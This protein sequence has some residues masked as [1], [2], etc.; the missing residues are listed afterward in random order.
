MPEFNAQLNAQ[1]QSVVSSISTMLQ[2]EAAVSTQQKQEALETLKRQKEQ[3]KAA[4]DARLVELKNIKN[5]L[6]TIN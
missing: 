2:Q 1:K 4:F 3:D 5:T 6:L